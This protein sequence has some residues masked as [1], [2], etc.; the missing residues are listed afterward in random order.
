MGLKV[1]II[2]MSQ[3]EPVGVAIPV[4]LCAEQHVSD[5]KTNITTPI[6]IAMTTLCLCRLPSRYTTG[7]PLGPTFPSSDW[8]SMEGGQSVYT[9]TTLTFD[10]KMH[11]TLPCHILHNGTI[12]QITYYLDLTFNLQ[13]L[14][15]SKHYSLC[16]IAES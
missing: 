15:L 7:L 10:F 4:S 12:H 5:T 14:D 9:S 1:M 8:C 2:M 3:F 6:P 16:H 11:S 13:H